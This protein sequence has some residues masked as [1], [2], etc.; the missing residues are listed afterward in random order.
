MQY[1]SGVLNPRRIGHWREFATQLKPFIKDFKRKT[2][3][4][5]QSNG[6]P[7]PDRINWDCKLDFPIYAKADAA[8]ALN[9]VPTPSIPKWFP[10]TTYDGIGSRLTNKGSFSRPTS[11]NSVPTKSISTGH[12]TGHSTLV[13]IAPNDDSLSEIVLRDSAVPSSAQDRAIDILQSLQSLQPKLSKLDKS[14]LDE[15]P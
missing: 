9:K 7:F 6:L 2:L 8:A 15:T 10:Q 12:K 5:K 3:S 1:A 13:S 4:L 11:S 14:D